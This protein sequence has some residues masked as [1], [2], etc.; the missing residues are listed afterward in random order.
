MKGVQGHIAY[1]QLADNTVHRLAPALSELTA[2]EWDNG[3]LFFQPTS[4]QVSNIHAGTG[5]SNIIPGQVRRGFQFP[6][7]HGIQTRNAA[8]TSDRC[9]R[10]SWTLNY[11]P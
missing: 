4:W 3:N 9:A 7:L 8:A 11:D 2:T 10:P 1:P 6:I 5:A